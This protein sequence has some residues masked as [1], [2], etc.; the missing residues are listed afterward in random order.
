MASVGRWLFQRFLPALLGSLLVILL[1]E[2]VPTASA[3]DGHCIWYGQCAA[4][5]KNTNC[6]YNGTAK[7]IEE[8][9][10]PYLKE[11][12]PDILAGGVSCCDKTQLATFD[13]MIKLVKAMLGRCP[14]CWK[15]F[16]QHICAMTCGP[17]HSLYLQPAAYE[18]FND[19]ARQGHAGKMSIL[20]EVLPAA[21]L[22]YD[23]WAA[24]Q[25]VSTACCV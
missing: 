9:A 25:P 12:C 23:L 4:K 7:V 20:L 17:Q 1:A 19:Q 22:R 5:G 14:S 15:S 21:H 13:N 18:K 8:D 16:L 24:A 3:E 2:N 6:A 11:Y 10:K